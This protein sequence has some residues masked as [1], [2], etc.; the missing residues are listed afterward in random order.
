M[1]NK[2][3]KSRGETQIIEGSD[4]DLSGIRR[5]DSAFLWKMTIS[6]DERELIPLVSKNGCVDLR[7]LRTARI[8]ASVSCPA[9]AMSDRLFVKLFVYYYMKET[10][11][12][13]DEPMLFA[14]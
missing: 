14:E 12:D 8:R 5:D 10:D 3:G 2:S 1:G 4:T 13:K 11:P 9:A 7:A 6:Q